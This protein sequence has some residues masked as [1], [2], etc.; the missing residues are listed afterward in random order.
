MAPLNGR[1]LRRLEVRRAVIVAVSICLAGLGVL[2]VEHVAAVMVGIAV[3][4]TG[5]FLSQSL[6]LGYV[7]RNARFSPGAAAGLYV[8][9]FY[10]GGS[11]GAV[12]PGLVLTMAGWLACVGLIAVVLGLGVALSRGM[13]EDER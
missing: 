7:G 11:L 13:V 12:V 6:A 3:F 9:C 2:L 8:C 1:L 5:I 4:I 10:V